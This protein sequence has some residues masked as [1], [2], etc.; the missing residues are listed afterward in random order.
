MSNYCTIA[1]GHPLHG[2]YHDGEYGFP[3]ADEGELFERL[4]LEIFQ[5]GLSW[6]LILRKR[7]AFQQAFAGFA[8]D[9]VAR[10]GARDIERLMADEG[11]VRNRLKIEATLANAKTAQGLRASHGGFAGWLDANHPHGLDAWIKL[12]RATFRFTGRE[13]VN[14]FLMS[15][16]Y[17]PG[18][19]AEGC[20]IHARIGRLSPPWMRAPRNAAPLDAYPGAPTPATAPPAPRRT[21]LKPGRRDRTAAPGAGGKKSAPG[22]EGKKAVPTPKGKKIMPAAKPGSAAPGAKKGLKKKPTRALKAGRGTRARK[23]P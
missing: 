22:P 1:P 8:V 15:T 19:H 4:T 21:A 20:P 10:F 13:V 2:P 12:F 16:G 23:M 11:I 18:A 5:A 3:L 6:V 17:L 7:P 14:E 9:R